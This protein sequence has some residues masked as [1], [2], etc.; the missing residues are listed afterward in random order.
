MF[1]STFCSNG[2]WAKRIGRGDAAA[3]QNEDCI[4]DSN[5]S[6]LWFERRR[7]R[8]R[9]AQRYCPTRSAN[10]QSHRY[11]LL[12]S[13]WNPTRLTNRPLTGGV[14]RRLPVQIKIQN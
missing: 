9:N 10:R 12:A 4:A 11:H 14:P 2:R 8:V 1:W 7:K 5:R 3:G 13:S 6:F